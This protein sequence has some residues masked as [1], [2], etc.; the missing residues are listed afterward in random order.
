MIT[1]KQSTELVVES[2]HGTLSTTKQMELEEHLG[3]CPY[4]QTFARQSG[5]I[6]TAIQKKEI[7]TKNFLSDEEKEEL[8]KAIENKI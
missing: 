4:C 5:L 1:C 7:V 3:D 8:A 6:T 2:E